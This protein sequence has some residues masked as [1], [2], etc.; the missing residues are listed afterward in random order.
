MPVNSVFMTLLF[1]LSTDSSVLMASTTFYP[2]LFIRYNIF[3][4]CD[5]Y[6]STNS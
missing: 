1:G 4:H 3:E 2:L 5:F 6:S